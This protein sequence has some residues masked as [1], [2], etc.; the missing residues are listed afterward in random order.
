MYSILLIHVFM[1]GASAALNT[2]TTYMSGGVNVGETCH[3]L[4]GVSGTL[5]PDT[6]KCKTGQKRRKGLEV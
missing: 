4:T 2:K 5:Q 3:M 6:C 1:S